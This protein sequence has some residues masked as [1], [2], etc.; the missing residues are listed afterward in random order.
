VEHRRT[1]FMISISNMIILGEYDGLFSGVSGCDKLPIVF[2]TSMAVHPS[3]V[4]SNHASNSPQ[5]RR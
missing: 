4:K 2:I 3:S 1:H 5:S